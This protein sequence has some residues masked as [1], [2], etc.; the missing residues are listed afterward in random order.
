MVLRPENLPRDPDVLI[1]MVLSQAAEI[2]KLRA[3]LKTI[4]AL[5]FGARSERLV[6]LVDAG[7]LALDLGDLAG[8][9]TPRAANDDGAN[10]EQGAGTEASK[11]P[12]PRRNI[13][14]LPKHLTRID[15]VLEPETTCCPCCA[16]AL[17]R[18]GEDVSEALDVVPAVLRVIRTIRP[19]Y[20]CRAC[21]GGIVQAPAR[22]RLMDGGMATTSLIAHV[23]VNKFAWHL[24]LSRQVQMFSGQGVHL[25]RS[26]LCKWVKRTAWWLSG[27]Y[28][29]QIAVIHSHERVFCDETR[30]PVRRTGRKRTHTGQFWAHAIDDRPW[31]GPAPPAVA[32]IF[33][34]G[35]GHREISQQLADY[36]GL[37]QVDGY[38]G[39]KGL[40]KP[41]REPGAITL[42]FCLAHARRKFTDLYKATRSN[43]AQDVVARLAEIYA[44]EAEIRG[45]QRGASAGGPSGPVGAADGTAQDRLDRRP[46]QGLHAIGAGR[47][48]PIHSGPLGRPDPVP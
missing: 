47:R 21:E 22:P 41:G 7:Q 17:H 11:R 14:L 8:D 3:A 20:A 5:A 42:A 16:G 37:L 28:R 18:I 13:G 36:Q 15:E 25:D 9:V 35:R 48:H 4:N 27:L 32:Y 2:E 34:S 29:R 26:S 44:I 12:K 46:C 45:H 33:A 24:P 31:N 10:T 39:Y 40:A 43:F 6:A 30:M 23:V 38:G 1:G 19:R